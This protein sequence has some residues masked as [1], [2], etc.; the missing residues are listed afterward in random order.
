MKKL[1][2]CFIYINSEEW[3]SLSSG[4]ST[5]QHYLCNT[6]CFFRVCLLLLIIIM[7]GEGFK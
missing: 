3:F 5:M 2:G 6:S 7:N 4:Y 1:G